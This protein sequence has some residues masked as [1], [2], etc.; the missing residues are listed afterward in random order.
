MSTSTSTNSHTPSHVHTPNAAAAAAAAS[1]LQS[2]PTGAVAHSKIPPSATCTYATAPSAAASPIISFP[3]AA[4]AHS[5]TPPATAST[6]SFA[7]AAAASP[8]STTTSIEAECT[9]HMLKEQ[10]N[11]PASASVAAKPLNIV[12]LDGTWNQAKHLNQKLDRML[13]GMRIFNTRTPRIL[14]LSNT[15]THALKKRT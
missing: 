2:S 15:V 8:S 6:H 10:K 13:S 12:I 9:P 5:T 3:T 7:T 14:L 4:D 11:S 1:S